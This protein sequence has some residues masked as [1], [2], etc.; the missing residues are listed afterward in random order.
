MAKD[1][2]IGHDKRPA[3][4]IQQER[5]LFNIRTG[6]PLTD[7][8][9]VQLVSQEDTFLTTESSS[10][11]ATS[12]AFTDQKTSFINER[13][14]IKGDSF[15]VNNNII[16]GVGTDFL[17]VLTK[18]DV[19]LLPT[20]GGG[21][22]Y[23][24]RTI[25]LVNSNTQITLLQSVSFNRTFTRLY[26]KRE[27]RQ[28]TV[29]KVEEQ[30]AEFSEVSTSLLGYPKAEAQ[31][32]LF[33]NVSSYGLDSDEFLWY[34]ASGS[35]N[36]PAVWE[37]RKNRTFGNHFRHR[38]R[39]AKQ[40][41]ALALEVF[42]V[43]YSYPFGPEFEP[44]GL[45]NETQ[46]IRF[47]NFMKLG[48][49][50]FDYYSNPANN[51]N[52]NSYKNEFFPYIKNHYTLT[53]VTGEFQEGEV[54]EGTSTG[55]SS[56][57]VL[58]WKPG[59]DVLHFNEAINLT[60]GETITGIDSGATA[61]VQSAL[62][63]NS[64]EY[65]Y[66]NFINPLNPYYKSIESFMGQIDTWTETWRDLSRGLFNSPAGTPIVQEFINNLPAVQQI[67]G[68][69]NI[70]PNQTIPGYST[71]FN[72]NIFLQSRKAFRYQP[73]R[74]SGYT[75]GTR[76]SGD[77]SD[78]NVV[79]EWGIGNPT[80]D[81]VFQIRG[82]AFNIVRRSVVPLSTQVLLENGLSESDQVNI[83]TEEE[84]M[85]ETIFSRDKWN[86]DTL[87][88]NGPSRYDWKADRVTMYK[89][90]FGWYGAIGV[91][92]YAFVPVRNDDARWVKLH[93]IVIENSLDRPCMGDP[94]YF[95]KYS[96]RVSNNLNLRTPQ[97]VYKYG[98]SCY[99]DGGDEGTVTV[100]SASS[101][102][103]Q[104]SGSD[105]NT[106]LA[107]NP[108]STI[109]N[110]LGIELKNKKSIFPKKIDVTSSGLTEIKIVKCRGCPGGFGQVYTPNLRSSQIGKTRLVSFVPT[111]ATTFDRSQIEL[112]LVNKTVVN[113]N[114]TNEITLNNVTNINS[115]DY[116]MPKF[117]QGGVNYFQDDTTIQRVIP[118]ENKIVLSKNLAN[119]FIDTTTIEI[120]PLFT[121][122]DFASKIIAPGIWNTYVGD[123]ATKLSNP[124]GIGE[125]LGYTT[126]RLEGWDR[127]TLTSDSQ[128]KTF[129]TSPLFAEYGGQIVTMPTQFAARFTN[130][131]SLA[132]SQIPVTGRVNKLRF[133]FPGASESFGQIAEWRVGVTYL[134]P[135]ETVDGIQWRDKNGQITELTEASKLVLEQNPFGTDRSFRGFEN[136][137]SYFGFV[138]PFTIDYRSGSPSGSYGGTCAEAELN[139]S[140]ALPISCEQIL[141]SQIPPDQV[142]EQHDNTAYYLRV[143]GTFG[144]DFN[145][146]GGEIGFN[147]VDQ[148]IPPQVGS[149]IYFSSDVKTYQDEVTVD[150]QTSIATFEYVKITSNLVAQTAPTE[151]ITIFYVP[152]EFIAYRKKAVK[153]L[154]YNPYPLHFFVEMRDNSSLNNI[155]IEEQTQYK[156][157][158]NPLWITN[159]GINILTTNVQ[160]GVIGSETTT[161]G[162]LTQAP[163]NY[164]A[165]DRLSSAEIDVQ[166]ES[167]LRPYEVIDTFYVSN[168]TKQIDLTN[169]FG[170]EK[171]VIT[172]DLLNTEAI[173]F[174]AKSK[175]L[176]D[177]FVQATLT[178]TEQQ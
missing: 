58:Q 57:T 67:F 36:S 48:T 107:V 59:Q 96:V 3:P 38:L 147:S 17:S 22:E 173:F 23:E 32:S 76:A 175:E 93:R 138:L 78:N 104:V 137:E 34:S 153:A 89:I 68:G 133:V 27:L 168:E 8:G 83:G 117:D 16:T 45:Y 130:Y 142:D 80:D 75:F 7:E 141:G 108:K 2:K 46:Y 135:E 73:G 52:N 169:I 82:G 69:Q 113:T 18:G 79:I 55:V 56:A 160:T 116:I 158:Y 70:F 164:E 65:F 174:I 74:I 154:N 12:V 106:L 30:F 151:E 114:G 4:L 134:K 63:Y 90:E 150:G 140:E 149:N 127:K 129:K 26:K 20:A 14:T 121:K 159:D 25:D 9:G 161:T 143:Q 13:V 31:L 71:A 148:L 11:K 110:P 15:Q 111:G 37:N 72:S 152:I 118:A 92:F 51:N 101:D 100:Y 155:I 163:P 66:D 86:G 10:Q 145:P 24:Q 47:N 166:N 112:P 77:A 139:I 102:L 178:Y 156:N 95:F 41:S 157:T 88:G 131:D 97:F 98:T 6:K 85:W 62:N 49:I 144:F 132:A 162:G 119:D 172:P 177:T 124:V 99:I 84:P 29:W 60:I 39:E 81:L 120:Q 136:G 40:E 109:T 123:S 5:P 19:L 43:P 167:I 115:G 126:A 105:Y 103:K 53:N 50:L 64:A 54:I 35:T 33:S 44:E 146:D 176:D 94:F 87:D 42:P 171:E 128:I 125:V 122:A 170:F 165:N 61:V 21:T 1:I 28:S 91:Q